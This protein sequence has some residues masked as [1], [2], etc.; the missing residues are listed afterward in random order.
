MAIT[1]NNST[2]VNPRRFKPIALTFLTVFLEFQI[3]ESE[4]KQ[5]HGLLARSPLQQLKF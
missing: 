1:T 4:G 3:V 2:N 5:V